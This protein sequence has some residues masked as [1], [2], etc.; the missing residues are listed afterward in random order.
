M[1][2]VPE[3]YVLS[4]EPRW[5]GRAAGASFNSEGR[6][7]GGTRTRGRDGGLILTNHPPLCRVAHARSGGLSFPF[8]S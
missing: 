8:R 2:R 3:V 5:L 6:F 1:R 4:M 7:G